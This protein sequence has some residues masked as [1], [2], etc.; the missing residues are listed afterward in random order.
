VILNRE[1]EVG[2]NE[3]TRFEQRFELAL[4]SGRMHNSAKAL[5]QKL[6]WYVRGTARRSV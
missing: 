1:V 2:F 4:V 6:I 3:K 5:I